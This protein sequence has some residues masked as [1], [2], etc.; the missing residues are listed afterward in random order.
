MRSAERS[1]ACPRD[2]IAGKRAPDTTLHGYNLLEGRV[3]VLFLVWLGMA[4][5]ALLRLRGAR[6]ST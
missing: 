3:W 4:P 2:L 6:K 5:S 1:R